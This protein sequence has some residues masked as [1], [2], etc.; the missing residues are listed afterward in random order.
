[1]KL[2]TSVCHVKFVLPAHASRFERVTLGWSRLDGVLHLVTLL[3]PSFLLNNDPNNDNDCLAFEL[4]PRASPCYSHPPTPTPPHRR[5]RHSTVSLGTINCHPS[6]GWSFTYR[7]LHPQTLVNVD[8]LEASQLDSYGCQC[9]FRH[10]SATRR[11]MQVPFFS[12]SNFK[13]VWPSA[14]GQEKI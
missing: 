4:N 10:S 11:T 5:I 13:T 1:M 6:M 12:L 8:H 2:A 9:W 7:Q 3:L 14:R